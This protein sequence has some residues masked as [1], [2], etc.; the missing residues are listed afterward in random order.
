MRLQ[1]HLD[2]LKDDLAQL[3]GVGD[4]AVAEAARR[5][6]AALEASL[7]VRLLD[8]LGEAALELSNAMGR[9]DGPGHVEVRLAG[10]DPELVFVQAEPQTAPTA[11]EDAFSA[12]ITLRLPESLKGSVEIAAARD[13]VSVNSWLVSALAR[14]VS[15]GSTRGSGPGRRRLTGYGRS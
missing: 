8:V 5:I 9:Q 6:A 10:G 2:A 13:G 7:R 4:E 3:A 15:G 12:R 1:R 11:A 14:S